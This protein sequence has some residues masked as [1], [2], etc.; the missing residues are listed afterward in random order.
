MLGLLKLYQS[1][2]NLGSAQELFLDAANAEKNEE[3][4]LN[5][6]AV[7]AALA[8]NYQMATATWKRQL[9]VN[10]KSEFA[11]QNLGLVMDM[12]QKKQLILKEDSLKKEVDLY[13]AA[14]EA[15]NAE[16]NPEVGFLFMYPPSD[17]FTAEEVSKFF[18]QT[19]R[20]KDAISASYEWKM[21][22]RR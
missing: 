1:T 7:V 14:T 12:I 5:N 9:K 2:G 10:P 20:K 13:I 21:I 17:E 8:R 16:F 4:T 3:I 22:Q 19:D 18:I 6:L 11:L 15:S